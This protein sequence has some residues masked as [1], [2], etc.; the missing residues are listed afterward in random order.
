MNQYIYVLHLIPRLFDESNW[1]SDDYAIVDKHFSNLKKLLI[2]EKLILAGRT[3]DEDDKKFGIVIF[4]AE[5]QELAE[6]IMLSDPAV[7]AG[8]MRAD[9]YPYR[10]ALMRKL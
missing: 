7:M 3:L 9:L 8:I 4:E 1:T 5:T 2:E 6:L 10:V